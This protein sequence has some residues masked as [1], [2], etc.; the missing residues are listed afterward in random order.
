V[1]KPKESPDPRFRSR[2]TPGQAE[3]ARKDHAGGKSL[4]EIA[5]ALGVARSS[6]R[7]VIDG[8]SHR[9]E[10]PEAELER[11]FDGDLSVR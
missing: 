2:I 10:I 11:I 3:Q 9:V 4:T 7:M 1:T 8:R 5:R 6:V